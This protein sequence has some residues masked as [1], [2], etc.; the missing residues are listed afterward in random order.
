[1]HSISPRHCY[2]SFL[3]S[4]GL[5]KY[6]IF[7]FSSSINLVIICFPIILVTQ[8]IITCLLHLLMFNKNRVFLVFFTSSLTLQGP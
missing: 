4:F 7:Q 1:M 5:L 8:E 6:F 3:Y 2:F